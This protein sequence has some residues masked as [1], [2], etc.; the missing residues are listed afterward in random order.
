MRMQNADRLGAS[1]RTRLRFRFGIEATAA[2]LGD[3]INQLMWLV[4]LERE[5]GPDPWHGHAGWWELSYS[6]FVMDFGPDIMLEMQRRFDSLGGAWI[7][8]H[9]THPEA[10]TPLMEWRFDHRRGRSKNCPFLR[11]GHASYFPAAWEGS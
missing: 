9:T 2:E 1:T 3:R 6:W 11:W 8:G 4:D 10:P 7:R 5:T